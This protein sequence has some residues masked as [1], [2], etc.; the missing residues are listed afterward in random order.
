MP[1]ISRAAARGDNSQRGLVRLRALV[2]AAAATSD[3]AEQTRS[4]AEAQA[5]LRDEVPLI[6]LGYGA[7]GR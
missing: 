5:I 7:A 3:A 4:Y 6:P 1:T 2:E